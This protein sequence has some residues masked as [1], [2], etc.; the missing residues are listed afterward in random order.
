MLLLPPP[1]RIERD[2]ECGAVAHAADTDT[3]R[4]RPFNRDELARVG[5][6]IHNIGLHGHEARSAA[7]L[8]QVQN[9]LIAHGGCRRPG[10]W[11][12]ARR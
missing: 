2:A 9:D 3:S 10:W 5:M 12:C 4:N 11:W 1:M 6:V 8:N 7:H